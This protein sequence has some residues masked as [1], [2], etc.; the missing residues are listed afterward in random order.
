MRA[1]KWNAPPVDTSNH[2]SALESLLPAIV[3]SEEVDV[4]PANHDVT[5]PDSCDDEKEDASAPSRRE[6]M[7]TKVA[8][9]KRR[10]AEWRK[11]RKKE[12]EYLDGQI[13]IA[14]DDRT[15]MAKSDPNNI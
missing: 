9:K 2:F 10:K 11:K 13:D 4:E 8:R 14:E 5:Q 12:E 3:P 1:K 6:K 15:V 7:I